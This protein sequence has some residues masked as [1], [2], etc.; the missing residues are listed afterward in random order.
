MRLIKYGIIGLLIL[1]SA[2]NAEAANKYKTR[3]NPFSNK[4]DYVIDTTSLE[5]G[6]L[7]AS[8]TVSGVVIMQSGVPVGS[9]SVAITQGTGVTCTPNPITGI[10]TVAIGQAVATTS[11]PTFVNVTASG[12]VTGLV[13]SA[14]S[15]LQ[16]GTDYI[17]D[18]TGTN[19]SIVGGKLTAAGGGESTT[20]SDTTTLDLTLAGAD[21]KGDVITLKDLVTTAPL[22]V[23]GTTNLDNVIVGADSDITLSITASSSAT[24]AGL[25]TDETGSSSGVMVFNNQP[26]FVSDIWFEGITTDENEI[27]IDVIDPVAD[28]TIVLPA[29]DGTFAVSATTPVTLNLTTGAI[30]LTVAKDIVAGV[31]LSGGEDNVLTG[32]DADTTL[33]LD[34]TEVEATTWGAG[35]NAANIWSFNVSGTDHTMTIGSALITFSGAVTSGGAITSSGTFDATGAVAMVIGSGD[36]TGLTITTDGTGNAE[37]TLPADVIG[38][39]DIDWGTGAGQVS[40]ADIT[41][42]EGDMTDSTIVSAD[43]KNGTIVVADLGIIANIPGMPHYLRLTIIDPL[44]VQT[45]DN[46]ICIW[47][48]TDAAITITQIEVSLDA[49]TNEIAGD[50][51]FA[52][53]FIALANATVIETFDTTSGVR[54]DSSMSGDATV[55]SGKCIYLSFDSAPNTAIHQANFVI[56]YDYD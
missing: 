21:I 41:F 24:W 12:T 23:N 6:D 37:L 46:E 8:G 53:T 7:T 22:T 32:A 42:A 2:Y 49:T 39:A 17:T 56:T 10:G 9:S 55:P 18:I 50:L 15:A 36:I 14:T 5:V 11:S 31:G 13:V 52:D 16:V 4:P 38:D 47:N 30:G 33:T 19:L 20:V 48:K 29:Q 54:S 27:L 26:T 25:I 45:E 40:G 43:I 44:S 28:K 3:Q 51:K 35:G 1:I 34:T